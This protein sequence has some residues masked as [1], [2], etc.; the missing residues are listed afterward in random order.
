MKSFLGLP[1]NHS[2]ALRNISIMLDAGLLLNSSTDNELSEIGL[3]L[4]ELTKRYSSEV[5]LVIP[6]Q[7]QNPTSLAT[8]ETATPQNSFAERLKLAL[9]YTEASQS[10]L[11]WA[12]GVSQST[13]SSYV[14][15]KV[16]EAGVIRSADMAR[17]LGVNVEWLIY[18]RGE[19]LPAKNLTKDS[20][21]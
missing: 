16:K 6:E 4:I 7:V 21:V 17:A 11:A 13:I 8:T 18:G 9:D 10:A 19:M 20:E 5:A 2:D 12:I 3:S 15:G 14:T 1:L